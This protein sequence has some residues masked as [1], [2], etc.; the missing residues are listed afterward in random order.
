MCLWEEACLTVL[1]CQEVAFEERGL[2][3]GGVLTSLF[4]RGWGC[5]AQ[6]W[7]CHSVGSEWDTM[8]GQCS[9]FVQGASLLESVV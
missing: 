2:P 1:G 6:N 3:G 4:E 8:W 5:Q 7:G 9:F